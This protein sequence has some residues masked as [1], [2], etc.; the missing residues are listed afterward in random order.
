MRWILVAVWSLLAGACSVT[1]I[2]DT[3]DV[4][5][6]TF[7]L[8]LASEV[9]CDKA[10]P[11]A[12]NT[13]NLG[14]WIGAGEGGLGYRAARYFRGGNEC[15]VIIWAESGTDAEALKDAFQGLDTICVAKGWGEPE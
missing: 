8:G 15:R 5:T 7:G 14:L 9:A 2:G 12:V 11:F 1:S 6:T 13:R 10:G 3:G 4:Q